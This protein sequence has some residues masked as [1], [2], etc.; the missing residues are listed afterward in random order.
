MGGLRVKQLW[1]AAGGPAFVLYLVAVAASLIRVADQPSLDVRIAGTEVSLVPADLAFAALLAVVVVRLARGRLPA[2]PGRGVLLAAAA[3]G[4]WLGLSALPNGATAIVATGRLL[5]LGILAVATAVLV[6]RREQ[7]WLLVG[8]LLLVTVAAVGVAFVGFLGDP[9][10]R[11]ASFLGEHD[12]AALSSMSLG[13]GLAAAY[14][15]GRLDRLALAVVVVGALGVTLGAA[16]ASVLGV[17][18]L[19][20]A[21]AVVAAVRGALHRRPVVITLIVLACVTAGTAAIRSGEL[22]FLQVL[23]RQEEER[24]GQYAASWSQRLIYAYIGLRVFEDNPVGGTGWYPLLPADEFAE[25]LP[26][27]RSRFPDQP[28]RYFPPTDRTFIPQQTPDQ[29][30]YELGLVG[31]VLF[32]L[33]AGVAVRSAWRTARDWPRGPDDLPAYVPAAWTSALAGTLAGS[34]LF[35]GTPIGAIFWLTIGAVAATAALVPVTAAAGETAETRRLAGA[36]P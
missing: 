23:T 17:Y 25:Y 21:I 31:A 20:G 13:V 16:L 30:L 27:A 11:Q 28:A 5:E 18:L 32:L 10:G 3:F 1:R 29:V 34:A 2:G 19:A 14:A 12:L 8:T 9:G 15:R 4:A 24:P 33:L 26:D 6:E 7:L 36:A 22:G 35:G